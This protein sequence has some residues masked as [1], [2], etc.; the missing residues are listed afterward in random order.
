MDLHER[1]E[2]VDLGLVRGELGQDAT[3]TERLYAKRRSDPV[4][5]RRRGIPFVEDQVDHLKDGGEAR[6]ALGATRDLEPDMR[7]GEGPLRADDPLG[8]GRDR[9]EEGPRDLL[10]R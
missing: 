7:L 3:Q 2:A 5:A 4:L 8:D 9:D 1:D 6:N 10:R